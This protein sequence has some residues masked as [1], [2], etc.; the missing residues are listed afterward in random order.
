MPEEMKQLILIGAGATGAAVLYRLK[1]AALEVTVLE[2]RE[3][4]WLGRAY[5]T[6]DLRHILNVPAE[7]MSLS[8]AEPSDF[9]D[10]LRA[11]HPGCESAEDW[12]FVPRAWFGE[13]VG[14][15]L[16]TRD[17]KH[18]KTAATGLRRQANR[19]K[20]STASGRELEADFVVLA[21]GYHDALAALPLKLDGPSRERIL[22]P[23]DHEGLQDFPADDR[24]L[25]V[26]TGL[27]GIDVFRT[28]RARGIS[29]ISF[30]S[31]H[32]FFPLTHLA[33]SLPALA[34]DHLAGKSSLEILRY[35]KS[36]GAADPRL[37]ADQLRLQASAIWKRWSEPERK[38]F[39]RHLKPY[40]ETARHRVPRSVWR[41]IAEGR[42]RGDL[43]IFAGRITKTEVG[44]DGVTVTFRPRGSSASER[45]AFDRVV[46]GHEVAIRQELAM[47]GLE[48]CAL[49][50]GY[51]AQT[52][53]GLWIAGPAS[54]SIDWEITAV[55]EIRAQAAIIAAEILREVK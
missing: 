28:L 38:R 1:R 3:K 42:D 12:P 19:W 7:R 43:K 21:T 40:W 14:E 48:A 41:E 36:L 33:E 34:L 17:F 52:M 4:P 20:V 39:L 37:V 8:G 54:K 45:V 24:V 22:Q 18:L 13:Y 27:T 46:L 23:Y 51:A 15:R 47:P 6:R 35:W 5:S 49:G 26:G 31:R 53:P 55:P 10:W 44:T 32:G 11:K 2:P 9:L 25:I 30:L 29:R 50:L 16:G